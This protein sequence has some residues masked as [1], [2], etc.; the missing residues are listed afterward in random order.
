ME[1]QRLFSLSQYPSDYHVQLAKFRVPYVSDMQ[2]CI[3][4]LTIAGAACG[5]HA[6]LQSQVFRLGFLKLILS[7]SLKIYHASRRVFM[8][9]TTSTTAKTLRKYGFA[10][11]GNLWEQSQRVLPRVSHSSTLN[12]GNVDNG[13]VFACKSRAPRQS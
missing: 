13:N 3:Q 6:S 12:N 11:G 1:A 10:A 4:K 5:E 7:L 8:I 2:P 9:E